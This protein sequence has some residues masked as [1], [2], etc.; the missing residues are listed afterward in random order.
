[1]RFFENRILQISGCTC[2]KTRERNYIRSRVA[3]QTSESLRN[4]S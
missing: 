4:L 3:M 1:M 2:C